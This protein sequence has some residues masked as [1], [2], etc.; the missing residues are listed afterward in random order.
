MLFSGLTQGVF[1]SHR[2]GLLIDILLVLQFPIFHSFFLSKRGR[3]FLQFLFPK[4]IGK[5]LV[6]TTFGLVASVQLLVVFLFWTP[7]GGVWFKPYGILLY[8]WSGFYI[9]SWGLLVRALWEA[10]LELH[11]GALGWTAVVREKRPEYPKPAMH[12]LHGAC[13]Q[14]IYLCFSLIILTAPVWGIDHVIIAVTWVLYCVIGPRLKEKRLLN[15]YGDSY[16]EYQE[17]T[18][19]M[20]PFGRL[21][22]GESN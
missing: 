19:Y 3:R 21:R 8:I 1:P 10:G 4:E 22:G 16:R 12:G 7:L 15:V 11:T 13:R 20:I 2:F 5:D 17:R 6:T 14:P 9:A 18:S